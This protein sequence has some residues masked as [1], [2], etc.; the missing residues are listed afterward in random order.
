MILTTLPDL[1]PRPETAANAPWRRR[2]YERWGREN[3][4]V[5]GHAARADYAVHPQ[6]L[7][8]KLACG[9]RERY[10]LA[11]R[12][13]VVDDDN[14]LVLNEGS[15]Y[16]S[17]L[18]AAAPPR[19]ARPAPAW[20]F[21]V[22]FRPGMQDDVA[23]E[24]GRTLAAALEAPEALAKSSGSAAP[25]SEHLRR[26]GDAVSRCLNALAHGV[27]GGESDEAW[28]EERLLALLERMLAAEGPLHPPAGTPRAA[29]RGE[30]K[31]RLREA[32]DFID[33][34]HAQP[35]T[36]ARMA[37]VACLSRYH[38]VREF[39]REYGLSPHAWL[40]RK[41]VRAA[42][43]F[44]AA[45]ARDAEWIAQRCG[46]GSRWSLSRALAGASA[47]KARAIAQFPHAGTAAS[48]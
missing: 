14:Y 1:P 3:A 18:E 44:I 34:Q 48:T 21:A 15:R 45:G 6:T 41:R 27:R 31:R 39:G 24:R 33:A 16:G 29:Q 25:F 47:P 35:L 36:L 22:F 42:K 9:G 4:I 28:L 38:F 43:R 2:F 40:T 7:S 5:C 30:L 12:E 8:I 26:H 32:A 17:V 46:F 20:T 23:V 10:L 37:E 13:V 19:G 11:R